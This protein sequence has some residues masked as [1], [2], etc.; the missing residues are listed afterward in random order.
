MV[1]LVAH[2]AGLELAVEEVGRIELDRRL[3]GRDLHHP[4]ADRLDDPRRQGQLAGLLLVEHV[5]VVVAA[6]DLV[7]P[8]TDR[9]GLGEVHRRTLDRGQAAGGDQ[10]AVDRQVMVGI[11][12]H[13]LVEDA[14]LGPAAQVPVG[15]IGEVD[16]RGLVGG[17]RV[18][19]LQLVV[20]IE[21][22]DHRG[23]E[24]AGV[25]FVAVGTEV[26]QLDAHK[27]LVLQ[28]LGLPDRLVEALLST[29]EVVGA[30]VGGQGI[31]LAVQREL[32]LG[33]AVGVAAGDGPEEGMSG[34]VVLERIQRQGDV[35][36][37]ALP[38]GRL[39]RGEDR[40]VG[41]HLDRQPMGVGQGKLVNLLTVG[42]DA[43]VLLLQAHLLLTSPSFHGP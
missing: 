41:H 24:V 13:Q 20:V 28:R 10:R 34:K 5:G 12:H 25:T 4:A 43:E 1:G 23:G 9:R 17:G 29:V 39:D 37:V 36:Q 40:A 7:D 32:A 16:G 35:G 3:R 27:I 38:I 19:H 6:G 26:R 14:A 2:A 42:R 18:V 21:R 15:V 8:R 11:D 31:G 33:D 22:V 30:V